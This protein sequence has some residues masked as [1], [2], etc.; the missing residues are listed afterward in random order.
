MTAR[1]DLHE[2]IDGLEDEL[3]VPPLHALV[4]SLPDE[5]VPEALRRMHFLR[6]RVTD[7]VV[8]GDT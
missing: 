4:D 2:F 7:P 5:L 8:R 3:V 1:D 6:A